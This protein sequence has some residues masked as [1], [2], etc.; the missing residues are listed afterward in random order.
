MQFLV[1]PKHRIHA[2]IGP[3]AHKTCEYIEKVRSRIG[4]RHAI[5]AD[6]ATTT[7]AWNDHSEK[8]EAMV[9][10]GCVHTDG[11]KHFK[12]RMVALQTYATSRAYLY[13]MLVCACSLNF[14]LMDFVES[15]SPCNPK[16]DIRSPES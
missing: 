16:T 7:D 6:V 5:E 12:N 1:H 15:P 3:H 9:S 14:A 10:I 2:T 4:M 13:S 8:V 11:L